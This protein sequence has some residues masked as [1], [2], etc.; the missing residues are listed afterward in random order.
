[1]CISKGFCFF[2]AVIPIGTLTL[3]SI[4]WKV[5]FS[6]PR[7]AAI[8]S[9][10][11]ILDRNMRQMFRILVF[12]TFDRCCVY[13]S[14]RFPSS[15]WI[16]WK[17]VEIKE[18]TLQIV[19]FVIQ[20]FCKLIECLKGTL[21]QTWKSPCMFLFIYKYYP[22]NFAFLILRI[23]ELFTGKFCVMLVY[24]HTETIEYVKK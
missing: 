11:L 15:V 8:F 1:M 6:N 5:T 3:S 9:K 10:A 4:E 16:S 22:E 2:A 18:S 20:C 19:A 21:I 24:K 14:C 12:V 17:Q 23:L 7:I 13:V